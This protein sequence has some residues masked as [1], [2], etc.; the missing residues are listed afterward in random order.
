MIKKITS[1]LFALVFCSTPSFAAY[2]SVGE[3]KE[4]LL[5]VQQ[6]PSWQL[7][8]TD[9][10]LA[11]GSIIGPGLCLAGII[12][13]SLNCC[14]PGSTTVGWGLFGAGTAIT[15]PVYG[16]LLC[17]KCLPNCSISQSNTEIQNEIRQQET[18][19]SLDARL[20]G[21]RL[22]ASGAYILN[23]DS[24]IIKRLDAGQVLSL[25]P[26][27]F[28]LFVKLVKQ[29][30]FGDTA[31]LLARQLLEFLDMTKQVLVKN[32][33]DIKTASLF[34]THPSFLDS[35]IVLIEPSMLEDCD[36]SSNLRRHELE[37]FGCSRISENAKIP[38]SLAERLRE[39]MAIFCCF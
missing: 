6:E 32:L 16:G 10:A 20:E 31:E 35:L 19:A 28:H 37:V 33:S 24:Q 26:V 11:S 38:G 17:R 18:Y 30:A 5:K 2:L 29:N 34:K 12:S 4:L 36:I 22:R 25:A 39:K 13:L 1:L 23:A 21:Y 3:T 27:D 7:D 8:Q 15:T 9:K 14:L